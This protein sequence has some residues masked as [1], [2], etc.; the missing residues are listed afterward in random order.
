MS[1]LVCYEIPF[2]GSHLI[3]AK[4]RG[5]RSCPYIP[6]Q[7]LRP[8]HL[9]WLILGVVAFSCTIVK[10]I[11]QRLAFILPALYIG[12][13]KIAFLIH[14][15]TAM[16]QKIGIMHLVQTS[17]GIKKTDVP[18]KL[19]TFQEGLTQSCHNLLFFRSQVIGIIPVHSREFHV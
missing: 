4:D 13:F 6:D 11:I 17:V 12:R 16:I 5:I 19:L 3:L 2:K 8:V 10:H 7:I 14:R 9:D 18:L 15:H 1:L